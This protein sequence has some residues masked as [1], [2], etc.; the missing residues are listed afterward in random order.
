MYKIVWI[1]PHSS[2]IQA[3]LIFGTESPK[4]Y[5]AKQGLDEDNCSGEVVFYVLI[6]TELKSRI[7]C[8]DFT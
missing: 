6:D 7:G 4:E 8:L 1:D 5:L 2:G 3:G